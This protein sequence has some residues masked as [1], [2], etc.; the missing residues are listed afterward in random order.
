ML[1]V[2]SLYFFTTGSMKDFA[3]ALLV[4]MVTG[5]Y[6]TIFIAMSFVYFWELQ[7]KKRIKKKQLGVSPV[8]A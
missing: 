4:G 3:A 8:K 7:A 6:A 2:A 5:V 1:A